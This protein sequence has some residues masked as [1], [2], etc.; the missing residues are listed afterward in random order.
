MY[1]TC[2]FDLYGTLVDI[3]TDEEKEELWERFALLYGYY[4]AKYDPKELRAAWHEQFEQWE[5]QWK[6]SQKKE[7]KEYPEVQ[8]EQIFSGLFE[9]KNVQVRSE[10]IEYMGQ[11]F[12]AMSTEYLRLYEGTEEMLAALRANG[13]KIYLLTNAQKIFTEPELRFLG[14]SQYFD[15][16]LISSECGF[17]KPD[18]RFYETLMDTYH[19]VKDSAVMVGN[20]RVCDIEGAKAA[21]LKTLYI[22]SNLSEDGE[23]PKADRVLEQMDM[24]KVKNILLSK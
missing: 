4:G 6:Y 8:V 16:I 23:M 14:I 22:H 17:K 24:E 10:T 11:F 1:K 13:K 2:I 12:R 9:A 19:I 3:H 21:G 5:T 20:D 18:L 7:Q 15:G